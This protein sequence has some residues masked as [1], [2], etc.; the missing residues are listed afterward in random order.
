M[1]QLTGINV[2]MFY[3]PVLFKTLGFGDDASL[4]SAVITGVVNVVSTFVSI[5]TVDKFGRRIF[6]GGRHS[7][8][9]LP[10]IR[11]ITPSVLEKRASAMVP[12]P[13]LFRLTALHYL[14][15]GNKRYVG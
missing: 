10:G 1:Y 11:S 14:K 12:L 13:T 3:V 4:V 2:I 9:H 7:D 6:S 15:E 5:A 8:V